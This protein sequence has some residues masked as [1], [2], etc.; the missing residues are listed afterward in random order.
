MPLV[1]VMD[2]RELAVS[3]QPMMPTVIVEHPHESP[4]TDLTP[5]GASSSF[6][7]ILVGTP[8]ANYFEAFI[9]PLKR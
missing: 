4:W 5:N 8:F 9:H 2:T 6:D 7:A 1:L 3:A